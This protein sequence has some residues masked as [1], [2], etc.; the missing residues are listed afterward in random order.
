[1]IE[2][3]FFLLGFGIVFFGGLYL[4]GYDINDFYEE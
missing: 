4:L 3:G 1:M 2:L